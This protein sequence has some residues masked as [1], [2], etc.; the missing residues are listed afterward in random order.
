MLDNCRLHVPFWL[1]HGLH[2]AVKICAVAP[3]CVVKR[4]RKN[5]PGQSA[6]VKRGG[7]A[8]AQGDVPVEGESPI[9][10]PEAVG[11]V[12]GEPSYQA[13][14]VPKEMGNAQSSQSR[15][16]LRG[17]DPVDLVHEKPDGQP[18]IPE[19]KF[20]APV[21]RATGS[22]VKVG[23]ACISQAR[24]TL[25]GSEAEDLVPVKP[26][27][28]NLSDGAYVGTS[29]SGQRSDALRATRAVWA[30]SS[31]ESGI[32]CEA[33][34]RAPEQVGVHLGEGDAFDPPDRPVGQ[35]VRYDVS[36]THQ[37]AP[38]SSPHQGVGDAAPDRVS[39]SKA[40]SR[41]VTTKARTKASQ[42]V[43]PEHDVKLAPPECVS[44]PRDHPQRE[45]SPAPSISDA[46]TVGVPYPEVQL[47]YNENQVARGGPGHG[48]SG[49]CATGIKAEAHN[50]SLRASEAITGPTG[51]PLGSSAEYAQQAMSSQLE[52]PSGA[53]SVFSLDV[54]RA[55]EL[56]APSSSAKTP[57][58]S[59]SSGQRV[60]AGA[61][62]DEVRPFQRRIFMGPTGVRDVPGKVSPPGKPRVVTP[63]SSRPVFTG[64]G[65]IP[66]RTECFPKR[67]A[68][69]PSSDRSEAPVLECVHGASASLPSGDR[70][71]PPRPPSPKRKKKEPESTSRSSGSASSD[72][73]ITQDCAEAF[74][75]KLDAR[76]T[77]SAGHP[78]F[79]FGSPEPGWWCS[80]CKR[81]FSTRRLLWG[82]RVCDYDIC[83]NCLVDSQ[84]G[85]FIT[86]A[87]VQNVAHEAIP[88][89]P[90]QDAA[91]EAIPSSAQAW[92][93]MKLLRASGVL[94][95]NDMFPDDLHLTLEVNGESLSVLGSSRAPG[96]KGGFRKVY[97][98]RG[99]G[100]AASIVVK[101]AENEA[102]NVNEVR[103]AAACPAAFTRIF[104]SGSIWV[105]L[106]A[107]GLCRAHYVITERVVPLT[108]LLDGPTLPSTAC[109]SLALQC[110]RVVFRATLAGIKCRDLG[111]KQW[112]L[113]V[114]PN[115]KFQDEISLQ[116][117]REGLTGEAFHLVILDANCCL[118]VPQASLLGPRKMASFWA[119]QTR[120]VG[121]PA[122]ERLQ[123]FIRAHN[124]NAR[125]CLSALTRDHVTGLCS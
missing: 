32:L 4:F 81:V 16:P 10:A 88:A 107:D 23:P 57:A 68:A 17:S 99:E 100:P 69:Y 3:V 114:P 53:I 5:P 110:C 28:K 113:K 75:A 103:S 20:S 108:A 22:H 18:V 11:S 43:E 120:L 61:M 58:V 70:P 62:V 9:Q 12:P 66:R 78:L 44:R 118:P 109:T 40:S 121:A 60:S 102:D 46:E 42:R 116:Q 73:G 48:S 82:C 86:P 77:C 124:F 72:E 92:P 27:G 8:N 15:D 24:A 50:N 47:G 64:P 76:P 52:T 21:G 19:P 111:Q 98:L 87:P 7:H 38:P 106:G 59:R 54:S 104:G 41:V 35:P 14:G 85:S 83:G 89:A 94:T 6:S 101:L 25:R 125:S 79:S 97:H 49:P 1:K 119:L 96:L 80:A 105:S 34:R 67:A 122:S 13:D 91:Q 93:S 115:F 51:N 95:G 84:G 112:G 36:C 74:L 123:A 65:S 56:V 26:D 71:L 55:R 29:P 63:L 37:H 30:W 31:G 2:R 45:V 90:V 33:E 39:A 117:V